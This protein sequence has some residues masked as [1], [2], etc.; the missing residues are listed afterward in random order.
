MQ[1]V[2]VLIIIIIII[3]EFSEQYQLHYKHMLESV[4]ENKKIRLY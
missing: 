3:N 2:H 1:C 4:P